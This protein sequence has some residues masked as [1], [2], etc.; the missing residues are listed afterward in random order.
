MLLSIWGGVG[1]R[2]GIHLYTFTIFNNRADLTDFKNILLEG[3][4]LVSLASFQIFGK[5]KIGN[6]LVV[7]KW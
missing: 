5:L 2:G 7:A 6:L 3:L 1:G 4:Y